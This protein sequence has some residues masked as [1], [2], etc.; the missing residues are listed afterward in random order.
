MPTPAWR[1][2]ASRLAGGPPE[3]KISVAA[4]I[5]RS[6]L[7]IESARG[8]RAGVAVPLP[9]FADGAHAP[10]INGGILRIN[11]CRPE[12]RLCR[13]RPVRPSDPVGSLPAPAHPCRRPAAAIHTHHKHRAES[14]VALH[15]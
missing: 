1:A 12:A 9:I 4:S 11:A 10:L 8:P 5:R 13:T 14:H 3:L 6:R 2:T 15:R 7:R